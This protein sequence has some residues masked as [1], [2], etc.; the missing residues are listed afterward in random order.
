MFEQL[1][2]Q[3]ATRF[4]LR[5]Q[6]PALLRELLK[7]I[8]SDS[9]GGI[10][11]FVE[12]FRSAGLGS[13]VSSWLGTGG[14][15][16]TL[17]AANVDN[18]M[19][20][21][22]GRTATKFGLSSGTVSSA[23]AF[24]VPEVIRKLAPSG[25]LPSNT[26]VLGKIGSFLTG[27]PET[28]RH[29]T[30][31]VGETA[32]RRSWWP[33]LLIPAA[34]LLAWFF[35]RTPAGT[36]DPRLS[37]SNQEGKITYSGQVRDEGTR[38]SILTALRSNFGE[39][40][41]E[42][43]ITV[44][45][46]VRKAPWTERIG[47]ILASLKTPGTEF[48]LDRN[49]VSVGGWL[50]AADRKSTTD[51]LRGLFGPEFNFGETGDKVSGAV[52]EATNRAIAALSG[53]GAGFKADALVGALNLGIINFS[54]GSS[55]VPVDDSELLKKAAAAI[56]TAPKGTK[57]EISGHTDNV[58]DSAANLKLSEAR[59]TAVKSALVAEGVPATML[60]AKG[61]G[62]SKP[63]ASNSSE[64][65]RFQNRRIEYS[66]VSQTIASTKANP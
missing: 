38:N 31:R 16:S 51:K 44:D 15:S 49:I 27:A 42:G 28:V 6:A 26:D 11:G 19:G 65:G 1:I 12:R 17:S 10:S 9:V 22:V 52:R 60:V 30:T 62:D 18:V 61:Y 33:W 59:A 55:T 56:K 20:D 40:N 34:L 66:P 48:S 63:K 14:P 13:I 54:T 47:D 43:E 37:V 39:G 45:K 57:I 21:F 23:L 5:D 32:R 7:Y 35:L 50:S 36:L 64:Y 46:N 25:V 8:T 24:L 4:G 41:I 2:D 58:G 29:A 3:L 53:L